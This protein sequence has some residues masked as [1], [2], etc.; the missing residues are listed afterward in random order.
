MLGNGKLL[1]PNLTAGQLYGVS[2]GRQ[3]PTSKTSSN[4]TVLPGRARYLSAEES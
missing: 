2:A 3:E 1:R 4:G